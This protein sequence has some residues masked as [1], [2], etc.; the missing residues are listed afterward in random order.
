MFDFAVSD[1][2]LIHCA[3]LLAADHFMLLGGNRTIAMSVFYQHKVEA[4]RIVNSRLGNPEL[5]TADG[6]VGTV[7]CLTIAEVFPH[8]EGS[9]HIDVSS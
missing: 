6:T 8:E 2:G 9:V 1:E 7:A 4:I 3:I 5:A